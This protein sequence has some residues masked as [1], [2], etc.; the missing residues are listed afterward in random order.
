MKTLILTL[1][2]ATTSLSFG[3]KMSDFFSGKNQVVLL[4]LDFTMCKFIGKDAFSNP[5]GMKNYAIKQWNKF[6][7]TEPRKYSMQT[8]FGLSD[9]YYYNSI[10]YFMTRNDQMVDVYRNITDEDHSLTAEEIE[11]NVKTYQTFEKNGYAVA[12]I[13]ES[14]NELTDKA[15]IWVTFID[16]ESKTVVY[17]ERME[18]RPGGAGQVNFWARAV[19]DIVTQLEKRKEELKSM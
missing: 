4:G 10:N 16:V 9:K 18:G 6:F 8:T 7:V 12:L 19:Y 15:Y 1:F 11:A 3:Q 13:V 14:F 2:L 5:E 17:T